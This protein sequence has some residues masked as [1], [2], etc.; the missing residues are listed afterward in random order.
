M[1]FFLCSSLFFFI[2]L[3]LSFFLLSYSPSSSFF[4]LKGLNNGSFGSCPQEVLKIQNN[5]RNEWLSN[6]DDFWYT[7]EERFKESSKAISTLINE[8]NIQNILIVD[9]LTF[10]FALLAHS[11][12]STITKPNTAIILSNF[13][14]NAV[15]K[16]VQH[17]SSI[18]Q[19]SPTIYT[20]TIPFPLLNPET[21]NEEIINAYKNTLE[22][23]KLSG[24]EIVLGLL[25]HITSLPSILMPIQELTQLYR[26]Y[27]VEEIIIDGAHTPGQIDISNITLLGGNYYLANIHKW[28]FAPPTAAFLWIDPNSPSVKQGKLHHPIVSHSYSTGI[29]SECSM[30]GSKDYSAMCSIPAAISYLEKLGGLHSIIERN[31]RICCNV[32]QKLGH[33]WNTS[34]YV[35]PSSITTS[36]GMVGIPSILGD[37]WEKSFE[38]RSL[39]R[40]KYNI[41]IQNPFPVKGD[42]LYIRIS[43]AVY[44]SEE[45]Y[46]F[47]R[48]ALLDILNDKLQQQK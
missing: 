32:M 29:Y 9:S 5:I 25:D 18:S 28:C 22:E 11:L 7:I 27:N 33:A 10:G 36:M 24:K 31:H 48:D 45:D 14:Y 21:I 30:L 46:D 34:N 19:Y 12:I 20:V 8:N 47:L 40:Q 42:R 2:P 1:F 26:E 3:L 38:L 41:V 37:T 6:P 17:Y 4:L 16:A 35:L 15:V 13:T 39:L 23:I 44:N 43:V